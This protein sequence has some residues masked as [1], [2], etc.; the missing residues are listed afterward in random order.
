MKRILVI[1]LIYLVFLSSCT[2][3]AEF[4]EVSDVSEESSSAEFSEEIE[5]DDTSGTES[6]LEYLP[7]P[8]LPSQADSLEG[9]IPEDW[10][11]VAEAEKESDGM[12]DLNGDNI[13]DIVGIVEHKDNIS[14]Y[15]ELYDMDKTSG[16][17]VLFAAFGQTDGSYKLSFQTTDIMISA[18]EGEQ[19]GGY[20]DMMVSGDNINIFYC[21]GNAGYNYF[22][23][24]LQYKN[25]E[26]FYVGEEQSSNYYSDQHNSFHTIT[27][28]NNGAYA[29]YDG[30][31]YGDAEITLMRIGTN[32]PTLKEYE[33]SQRYVPTSDFYKA[34]LKPDKIT[35]L[36]GIDLQTEDIVLP[37][38]M[39][40]QWYNMHY[41]KKDFMVYS[42]RIKNN[43]DDDYGHTYFVAYNINTKELTVF[44]GGKAPMV[45]SVG[46]E[47][48]RLYV[49]FPKTIKYY[50]LYTFE[51]I[52][53]FDTEKQIFDSSFSVEQTADRFLIKPYNICIDLDGNVYENAYEYYEIDS[54]DIFNENNYFNHDD[55]L[56]IW[57]DFIK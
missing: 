12:V 13:E 36:D 41:S 18:A 35:I 54:S 47:K 56:A 20:Y 49:K 10:V 3:K 52:T 23:K 21:K 39:V 9:F 24:I 57:E 15:Y 45:I 50:D 1:I 26:W 6:E 16:P 44:C 34:V 11:V 22:H 7:T 38:E 5:L 27:D 30:G 43:D 33:E 25:G 55:F 53:I 46:L 4:P 28:Y 8:T 40:N 48:D 51:E 14:G 19:F 29:K 17:R 37:H 42:F 31:E 2:T 32:P